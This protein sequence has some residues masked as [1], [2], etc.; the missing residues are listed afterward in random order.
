MNFNSIM[1][2]RNGYFQMACDN[3]SNIKPGLVSERVIILVMIAKTLW[4]RGGVCYLIW[5]Q[6]RSIVDT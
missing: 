2:L 6:I 3:L 5:L 4:M 1:W